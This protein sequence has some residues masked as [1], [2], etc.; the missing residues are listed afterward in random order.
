MVTRPMG[1]RPMRRAPC[2]RKCLAH[3]WRRGLNRGVSFPVAGSRLL[4]S[5][6]LCELQKTQTDYTRSSALSTLSASSHN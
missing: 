6:P 5:E 2:Q 4:M 3:L 1:V